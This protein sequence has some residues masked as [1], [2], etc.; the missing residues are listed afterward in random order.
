MTQYEQLRQFNR[1]RRGDDD[2]P[3]PNPTELGKLLDRVA[4]RLEAMETATPIDPSMASMTVEQ[5]LSWSDH[6]CEPEAVERLRSRKVAQVLARCVRE[7][8]AEINELA[9]AFI[10]IWISDDH[11][12]WDAKAARRFDELLAKYGK[13][14]E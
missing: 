8:Q 3:Q 4:D 14:A 5:A 10:V 2:S 9:T 1:W 12:A 6:N 11:A 13:R 7:Q